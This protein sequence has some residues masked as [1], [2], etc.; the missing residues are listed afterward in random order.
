MSLPP[1]YFF[2]RYTLAA[3]DLSYEGSIRTGEVDEKVRKS[4]DRAECAPRREAWPW[5]LHP[6]RSH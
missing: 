4:P 2:V 1:T 6:H 5:Q 3:G